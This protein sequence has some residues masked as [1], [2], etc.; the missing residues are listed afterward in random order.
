MDRVIFIY[1]HKIRY[2]SWSHFFSGC[3]PFAQQLESFLV[4]CHVDMW[5]PA[6]FPGP[7]EKEIPCLGMG[8]LCDGTHRWMHCT[9]VTWREAIEMKY[10][11]G[12]RPDIMLLHPLW[13]TVPLLLFFFPGGNKSLVPF[14][15]VCCDRMIWNLSFFLADVFSIIFPF[16]YFLDL[17]QKPP[18]G[19]V[20]CAKQ[21]FKP[22]SIQWRLQKEQRLAMKLTKDRCFEGRYK[23]DQIHHCCHFDFMLFFPHFFVCS[24]F[25]PTCVFFSSYF[26]NCWQAMKKSQCDK[27][28]QRLKQHV[29]FL[30]VFFF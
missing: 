29:W 12:K 8:Q 19:T 7:C 24:P 18:A 14:F 20:R 10:W 25:F 16:F 2:R 26:P 11:W 5:F 28:I 3:G 9:T 4:I 6:L 15:A 30:S 17:I 1:I 23:L 13:R 27:W 21:S 22:S